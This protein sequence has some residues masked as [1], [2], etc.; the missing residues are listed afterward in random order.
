MMR[1]LAMWAL[2]FACGLLVGYM[3]ATPEWVIR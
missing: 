1:P 3:T 2:G